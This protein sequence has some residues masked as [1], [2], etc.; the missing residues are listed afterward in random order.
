MHATKRSIPVRVIAVICSGSFSGTLTRSASLIDHELVIRFRR[1]VCTLTG[2][3]LPP[4]PLLKISLHSW[5]F[6]TGD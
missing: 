3:S 1:P 4:A 2:A 5:S 6:E